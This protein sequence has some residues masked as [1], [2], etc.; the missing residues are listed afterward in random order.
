MT[1]IITGPRATVP[2]PNPDLAY[3][4]LVERLIRGFPKDPALRLAR[5]DDIERKLR[6]GTG[7]YWQSAA[8]LVLEKIRDLRARYP[9]LP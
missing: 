9:E 3:W 8:D 2:R 6:R 7:P 5:L 4:D 1:V